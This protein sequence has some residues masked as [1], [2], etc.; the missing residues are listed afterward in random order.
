[1]VYIN[2]FFFPYLFIF[3]FFG[4]QNIEYENVKIGIL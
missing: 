1:M 2:N 3:I 4:S